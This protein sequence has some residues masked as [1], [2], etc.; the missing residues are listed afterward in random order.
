MD[1]DNYCDD[2]KHECGG[3]ILVA[4]HD[5]DTWAAVQRGIG[6]RRSNKVAVVGSLA[7]ALSI[8]FVVPA[9]A[10]YVHKVPMELSFVYCYASTSDINDPGTFQGPAQVSFTSPDGDTTDPALT[11]LMPFA[12]CEGN[13]E[14]GHFS[15]TKPYIRV[16]GPGPDLIPGLPVPPLVACIRS[17]GVI[18]VF[19]GDEHTCADLDM[20]IADIQSQKALTEG[21]AP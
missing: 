11:G 19:P 17:N 3:H 4:D 2:L 18:G 5:A 12:A 20:P 10:D 15:Q 16:P 21:V 7:A 8:A 13:W 9:A 14:S 6:R 1:H